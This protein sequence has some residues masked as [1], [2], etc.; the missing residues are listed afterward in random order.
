MPALPC[1]VCQ[2]WRLAFAMRAFIK[3]AIKNAA[4]QAF[5]SL[6]LRLFSIR[7]R[8]LIEAQV[9]SLG[10]AALARE[11]SAATGGKVASGPF[12]GMKLDYDA[13]PV[14]AAPKFLGTYEQELNSYIE[15]VIGFAP[16]FVLNIGCAE[17][18]YAVGLAMRLPDSQVFV[19]D[20]DPKALRATLRNA[21]LNN[22]QNRVR[23]VGIVKSG[24]FHNYL[25]PDVSFLVMD[26]EGAEFTLLNPMKDPILSRTYILV[27]VHPEFGSET[28][29]AARFA[30]THRIQTIKQLSRSVADIRPIPGIDLLLAMEERRSEG[31][32]LFLEPLHRDC[33]TATRG[34]S[35]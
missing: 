21:E 27:E 8:R 18:F 4:V 33:C 31:R 6:S 1:E 28:D 32:W 19:A 30:K 11:V 12:A 9:Q 15:R 14:H 10:L 29:I 24:R 35:S 2:I 20:A 7:S 3:R 17:G 34:R 25:E 23:G 22:V 5:P 13:L 16:R 26:C